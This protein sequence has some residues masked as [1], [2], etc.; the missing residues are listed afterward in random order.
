MSVLVLQEVDD[1]IVDE[2]HPEFPDGDP[3]EFSDYRDCDI[4]GESFIKDVVDLCKPRQ[5]YLMQDG[6]CICGNCVPHLE[7]GC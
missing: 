1:I 3:M 2:S 6:T 7:E 5:F 4:C